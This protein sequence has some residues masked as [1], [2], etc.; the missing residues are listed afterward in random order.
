M[1]WGMGSRVPLDGLSWPERPV[2]R[3]LPFEGG[4]VTSLRSIKERRL[5]SIPEDRTI[6]LLERAGFRSRLPFMLIGA[7]MGSTLMIW[8][9]W[10]ESDADSPDWTD[11]LFG[12]PGVAALAGAL[13][14]WIYWRIVIGRTHHPL[15]DKHPPAS[16]D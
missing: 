15:S 4:H 7:V 10:W 3:E 8:L 13:C 1:R 11:I 9:P 5:G 6:W 2:A 14:G 16:H 12:P